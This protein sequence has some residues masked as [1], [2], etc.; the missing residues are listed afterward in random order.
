MWFVLLSTAIA[1][2]GRVTDTWPL[3]VDI[4]DIAVAT[5]GLSVAVVEKSTDQ[6]RVLDTRTWSQETGD[7]SACGEGVN[8]VVAFDVDGAPGYYVGCGGG[9]IVPISVEGSSVAAA[10]GSISVADGEI[11]ALTT[12]GELVYALEEDAEGDLILH[13]VD[14]SDGAVD[15]VDGYPS[16]LGYDGVVDIVHN[17]TYVIVFHG[18][19]NVS[20]IVAS[21]G[22][23]VVND[24]MLSSAKCSDAATGSAGQIYAAC[25]AAGVTT[26]DVGANEMSILLD[27]GDGL[28]DPT[29]LWFDESDD[30]QG[31]LI[32]ADAGLDEIVSF[33][34][35]ASSG[36][37][38]DEITDSTALGG[39]TIE[40]IVG[41]DG[42]LYVSTAEGELWVLTEAPW[43]EISA[44]EPSSAVTGDEVTLAFSSDTD[45]SY[46]VLLGGDDDSSGDELASGTLDADETITVPITVNDDYV[47]GLNAIRVVV[48]ASGETGHDVAELDVDNPPGRVSLNGSNIGFGDGHISLSFSGVADED[49]DHYEIY[50]T[51]SEF[52]RDDWSSGGPDFDGSDTLSTPIEVS[53]AAGEDVEYEISSLSNGTT[54]YVAVRAV[55]AGGLE[56]SMSNVVSATPQET[57]SVSELSDEQGGCSTGGHRVAPFAVG[58]ALLGLLRRRG[59][60]LAA[61]GLL[62]AVPASA[63]EDAEIQPKMAMQLRYGR[64]DFAE[65]NAIVDVFGETGNQVLMLE[66][67]PTWRGIVGMDLGIGFFN[68]VGTKVGEDGSASDESDRLTIIPLTAGATVRLDILREQPLVPYASAGVDYWM[69]RDKWEDSTGDD[70][71]TGGKY[72]WHYALGG[73]MLLD[74]FEPDRASAVQA[75]AGIDDAYI[76]V[77]WRNQVIGA[78]ED[79]LDF[80]ASAISGGLRLHY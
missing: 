47:E 28:D 35:S 18:G 30:D 39:V 63:D 57:F 19:D 78:Y 36:A 2:P 22:A 8:A 41:A 46:T 48:T 56:G 11:V 37:P 29:A 77:E 3:G 14:P 17:G 73:Q 7:I 26:F 65:D 64:I 67:G 21:S 55:D 71:L 40:E 23:A 15:A 12:D 61:L 60:A 25:G 69:W 66:G 24:D 70:T 49:L 31:W 72:G 76:T 52:D 32:V 38:D 5:D 50:V 10:D 58:L 80:T 4:L 62:V 79:G 68:E 33:A 45:G 59:A 44:L 20:K 43:V 16:T 13:T 27:E 74:L 75:R 54:Y 42:Y 9:S 34:L 51:V 1:S 6:V 53:A